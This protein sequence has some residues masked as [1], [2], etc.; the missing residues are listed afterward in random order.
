MNSNLEF[1]RTKM[2]LAHDATIVSVYKDYLVTPAGK[3]VCYDLVRHKAGGGAG[4]LLVDSDEKVYLIKQYR[5]TINRVNLEIPAGGYSSHDEPG[6]VCALREAEE[7]SGFIPENLYHVVNTI[8]SIGAY[9]EK[10][11]IFIGTKLKEGKV[12]LDENEFVELVKIGIDE[13]VKMIYTGEIIDSKTVIA[14]FSYLEMKS[15]NAIEI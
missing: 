5:N 9:D 8:S 14:L 7:E 4:I 12:K 1:K 3:E 13:A 2:E 15:R 6:E 11:D 10:T